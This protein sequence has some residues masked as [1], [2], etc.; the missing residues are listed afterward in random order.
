MKKIIALLVFLMLCLPA[1]AAERTFLEKNMGGEIL[2]TPEYI[3]KVMDIDVIDSQL[4]LPG[5]ELIITN[6]YVINPD[7]GTKVE[8]EYIRWK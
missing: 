8:I 5:D 6:G 7:D 2:V 4:W 1:F 3:I